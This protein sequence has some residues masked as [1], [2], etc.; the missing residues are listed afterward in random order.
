MFSRLSKA[1]TK[2]ERLISQFLD[3]NVLEEV[4]CRYLHWWWVYWSWGLGV[5][6]GPGITNVGT[7]LERRTW[8]VAH[9]LIPHC[10]KYQYLK[11]QE[12]VIVPAFAPR[13]QPHHLPWHL[14]L[15]LWYPWQ[16]DKKSPRHSTQK[17]YERLSQP[18]PSP[19]WLDSQTNNLF[20]FFW[21]KN[22]PFI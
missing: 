22:G 12:D 13:E 7:K 18:E 11:Y 14:L 10:L 21:F 2:K 9:Y 4:D 3:Q 17:L 1:T 16:C 6:V 15:R 19:C 8:I 20:F 5:N